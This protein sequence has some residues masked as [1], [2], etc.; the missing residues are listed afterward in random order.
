MLYRAIHTIAG[1]IR[2]ATYVNGDAD[3]AAETASYAASGISGLFVAPI[4]AEEFPNAQAAVADDSYYIEIVGGTPT[5]I[6]SP[7][8][9]G[10]Y[11]D[12][13]FATHTW[14]VSADRLAQA[15][16]NKMAQLN[17]EF[18]TRRQ[19]P[20]LFNGNPYSPSDEMVRDLRSFIEN[21]DYFGF[22]PSMWNGIRSTNGGRTPIH[23]TPEDE[24]SYLRGMLAGMEQRRA[25]C[26]AVLYSHQNGIDES[27]TVDAVLAYDLSG[28]WP[29]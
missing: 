21:L 18:M 24:I 4:T 6:Q 17:A 28:G 13:D 3:L 19:A 26:L 29:T 9:P 15:K 8:K 7:A 23:Y 11:Y 2:A 1:E 25:Q 22:N 5:L 20:I 12:F 27:A 10:D 16:Q 14:V